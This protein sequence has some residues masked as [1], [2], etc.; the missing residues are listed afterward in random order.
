[1]LKGHGH[2]ERHSVHVQQAL[3]HECAEL[4]RRL[5]VNASVHHAKLQ[6]FVEDT[7]RKQGARLDLQ[8]KILRID[9]V[10]RKKEKMITKIQ[11]QLEVEVEVVKNLELD[12]HKISERTDFLQ[13]NVKAQLSEV[14]R[15]RFKQ[16]E[17]SVD[18][19]ALRDRIVEQIDDVFLKKLS[20]ERHEDS[21]KQ[22]QTSMLEYTRRKYNKLRRI[23][24]QW[25]TAWPAMNLW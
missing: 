9:H 7:N 22:M 3:L 25:R 16:H 13:K 5:G 11:K 1:M 12:S 4:E 6:D 21:H 15:M 19:G 17:K 18:L 10:I 24:E 2:H 14:R 20:I 8:K 23:Y